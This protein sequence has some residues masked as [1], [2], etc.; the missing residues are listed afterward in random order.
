V[1]V[2]PSLVLES[3]KVALALPPQ[4]TRA[5]PFLASR[6]RSLATVQHAP[7]PLDLRC[8][9]K[10][11]LSGTDGISGQAIGIGSQ[12]KVTEFSLSAYSRS[13]NAAR[14]GAARLS[15][16]SI[17]ARIRQT[18]NRARSGIISCVACSSPRLSGVD[19]DRGPITTQSGHDGER[20]RQ[21]AAPRI[22]SIATPKVLLLAL[23]GDTSNPERRASD[24]Q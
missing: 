6:R 15:L 10:P 14:S 12:K 17:F 20:I 2:S 11:L 22:H 21:S 23:P 5:S 9:P 13:K 16:R 19:R 4:Q 3:S 18:T 1:G 7:H 24:F 8:L